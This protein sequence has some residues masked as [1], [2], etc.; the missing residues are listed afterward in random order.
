M[1]WWQTLLVALGSSLAGGGLTSWATWRVFR[2]QERQALAREIRGHLGEFAGALVVAVGFISQTPPN[3]PD[4]SLARLVPKR[5]RR[6]V[7]GGVQRW[8]AANRWATQQRQMRRALGDQPFL[9]A[10]RVVLAAAPLR[11]FPLPPALRDEIERV[12]DYVIELSD[13]RN[14]E[15]KDRWPE[16]HRR[17][18]GLVQAYVADAD[19]VLRALGKPP[20]LPASDPAPGA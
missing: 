19:E 18:Y 13:T 16:V 17:F 3:A 14:D 8:V 7:P 9:Y 4:L 11:V 15:V 1:D 12:L 5:V 6:R 10:E 20:A 2:W